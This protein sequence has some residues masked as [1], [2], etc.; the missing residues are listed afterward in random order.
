M[1]VLDPEFIGSL[2]PPKNLSEVNTVN[3]KIPT[4]VPYARLPRMERLRVSGK[5]DETDDQSDEAASDGEGKSK[6]TKVE[7]EKHKMRGKSKS[8]KRYLRKQRKNVIDPT[9]VYPFFFDLLL[10]LIFSL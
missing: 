9:T 4:E 10:S 3:G 5:I 6:M 8:T 7:K 1:I 2:A